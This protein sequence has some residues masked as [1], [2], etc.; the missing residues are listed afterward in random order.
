MINL[1]LNNPHLVIYLGG[2]ER[3]YIK[4]TL[5]DDLLPMTDYIKNYL[6]ELKIAKHNYKKLKKQIYK[7]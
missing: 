7:L 4:N 2:Y 3:F 5:T 1:K 6:D